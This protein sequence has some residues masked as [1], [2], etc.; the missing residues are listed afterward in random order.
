MN[1]CIYEVQ[2]LVEHILKNKLVSFLHGS[3]GIGKSTLVKNIADKYNLELIDVR[4][5]QC[6]PVD[7]LGF[8]SLDGSKASYKPMNLFPI[9]GD[10][11]PKGKNGWLLFL[12]EMNS[13][14]LST[15]K[16]SYRLVLDR[17][18]G[19]HKLHPNTVIIA[20]GNLQT[21]NAIVEDMSTALQSRLIHLEVGIKIDNWLNWANE[22]G[23]DYRIIG[24][25]SFRPSLLCGNL[26]HENLT[27]PCP[28][29]WDFLSRLIKGI[30]DNYFLQ[31]MSIATIGEGTGNEF[32]SFCSLFEKVPVWK[33]IITKPDKVEVPDDPATCYALSA[34][35]LEQVTKDSLEPVIAYISRMPK[36]FQVISI[37]NILSRHKTLIDHPVLKQ[38]I[39]TN[40]HA[41]A[42]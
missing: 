37:K 21:D 10:S 34:L 31:S 38:W 39:V 33:D 23:I 17:E 8:P 15:Q 28:R 22:V 32:T 12:D 13:A 35:I 5:S 1:H 30:T 20:A 26:N 11:L 6:E 27:F 9:E 14:D 41:V 16:A 40:A 25:L 18:V 42:A 29:T 24:F 19:N 4:L 2:S 36:E 7:L 3:P